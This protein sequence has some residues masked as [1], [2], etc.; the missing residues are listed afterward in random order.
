MAITVS[1]LNGLDL[2]GKP[3][4]GLSVGSGVVINSADILIKGD[5]V[6]ELGNQSDKVISQKAITD[7]LYGEKTNVVVQG[8]KG[9]SVEP[10][11]GTVP[12][13]VLGLSEMFG[14]KIA[15]HENCGNY[16][17]FNGSIVC[18]MPRKWYRVGNST[19]SM[20]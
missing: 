11:P 14:T 20:V 2:D 3:I 9:F 6:H 4:S 10:C 17:H 19:C 8:K 12:Y 18:F 7:I 16:I 13:A 15:G 1:G 5:V